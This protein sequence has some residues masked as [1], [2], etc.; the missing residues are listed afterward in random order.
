MLS[1]HV[2]LGAA[3]YR[4]AD[5]ARDTSPEVHRRGHRPGRRAGGG[6]RSQLHGLF[7]LLHRRSIAAEWPN[8]SLRSGLRSWC[9]DGLSLSAGLHPRVRAAVDCPLPGR[10]LGVASPEYRRDRPGGGVDRI[11]VQRALL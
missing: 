2:S 8:R 4:S 10:R 1:T 9:G 7:R 3:R 11:L 5:E 6:V